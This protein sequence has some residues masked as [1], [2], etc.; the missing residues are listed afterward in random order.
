VDPDDPRAPSQEIWDQLSPEERAAVVDSLPSEFP[1]SEASPPEGDLHFNAKVNARLT[2]GD[3]FTRVHRRV[4]LACELPV[5]YPGEAMFAPDVI[6]VLD[7]ENH[8]REKWVVA[9]EGKGVD[10]ALEVHVAGNRRKDLVK[11][12]EKYAR[13]GIQE[14]FI[15]DRG[16][17]VL[18]GYR[19]S[20]EGKVYEPIVP[21]AGRYTSQVLQLDLA[22]E[23]SR[24]RFYYGSA[25]LLEAE[26]LVLRL[27]GMLNEVEARARLAEERA[28]EEARGREQEARG[29]EQE[30]RGRREAEMRLQ[31]ALQE[32][33]RLKQTR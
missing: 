28:E 10:F 4:Y 22:V 33:E 13:L 17:L 16:R 31:E 21:Q 19:L 5:Y 14:Y 3:F 12:A 11:N 20:K 6:A 8:S 9:Q 15:F 7:V 25:P 27:E 1:P 23:A 24:L 18:V 29:R 2:L 26:E 32:I 30:A